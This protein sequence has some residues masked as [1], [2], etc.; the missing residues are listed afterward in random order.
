MTPLL[1]LSAAA[2]CGYLWAK[3]RK[4]PPQ[5]AQSTPGPPEATAELGLVPPDEL[6][7]ADACAPD[8]RDE[9]IRATVRSGDWRAGAAFL[10]EA[11]R[12]W[13]E[14]YR[15]AAVLQDEAAADDAWLLAWRAARPKDAGAALVHA[16]ALTGVAAQVHGTKPTQRPT[17]EQSSVFHQVMVRAREACHQAQALAGD[18]PCP[19]IAEIPCALG[20]GYE[21]A[22]CRALWAEVVERDAPHLAAHDAVLRYWCHKWRGSHAPAECFA[23]EAARQGAP[24][25]LL[26]LLPLYAAFKQERADRNTDEDVYYK[27]PELIAAAD[28]CL[29]DVAAAVAADPGDRRILRARHLLAWTLYWQDRYEEAV[30]Q[31]RAIDGHFDAAAPWSYFRDPKKYY[32]Q[33][34]GYSARRVVEANG[35]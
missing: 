10:D 22:E 2:L 23:R 28:L 15:R 27:S 26:S 35:N 12:D 24:G 25:R 34:R 11:G 3:A 19:Y 33:C 20:L 32:V 16:G 14:R 6:D 4:K 9:E 31:F 18:D 17:W 8:P 21:P 13:Q 7:T 30:E 29:V 5:T 1:L